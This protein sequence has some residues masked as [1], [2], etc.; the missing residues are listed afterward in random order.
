MKNIDIQQI[1]DWFKDYADSFLTGE[2]VHDTNIKLKIEHSYKVFD[3]MDAICDELAL[4]GS[5]RFIA[6]ACA[7]LHDTGRFIQYKKYRTFAD[8]RSEKHGKLGFDAIT[9]NSVLV[10][11]TEREADLICMAVLY[12]NS[13]FIPDSLNA[14]Q[15]Y[16]TELTRDADKIDI[17]RV[18]TDYYNDKSDAK[19]LTLVHN[20]PDLPEISD[21][22]YSDFMSDGHVDFNDL[23][24]VSDFKVF[25]AGWLWDFNTRAALKILVKSGY[26]KKLI[27][28]L[29]D[30]EYGQSVADKCRS[31]LSKIENEKKL[32]WKELSREK[33][34]E[35]SIFNLCSSQ[36]EASDGRVATAY[37]IEAPDWVTVIPLINKDGKDYFVMVRQYRHGAMRLTT[38]FPAGT[39]EEGEEPSVAALRELEEETGYKAGKIT[40]LGS[41]NANPAFLTNRFTAFLAEDLVATGVQT[42]DDNEYVDYELVPAAEVI[43]KMGSGEYSNG[44]MLIALM[45]Y[46]R[47]Q[48]KISSSF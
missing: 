41:V 15:R 14:E 23:K 26:M 38:E 37:M 47:E 4:K 45:Y 7:M 3:A 40:F 27:D 20:L 43:A 28:F 42:L 8:N 12:H 6:L 17:L 31:F 24:T 2:A 25:Q 29:P 21:K 1:K 46:L 5:D 48:G 35:C 33:M 19:D 39:I 11:L 18:I 13:R 9:Q 32:E 30:N 34:H 44:T 22:V 16:F 36:R 10:N